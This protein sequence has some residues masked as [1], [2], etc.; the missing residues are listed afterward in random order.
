MSATA[1]FSSRCRTDDVPGIS[2]TF[3]AT[4]SVH[5]S[6]ICAGVRPSLLCRPPDHRVAED[7]IVRSEGGAER[8]ERNER[9]VVFDAGVEHRLRSP[10]D[11]VVGV[12]HADDLGA[13]QRDLQMLNDD[14]AQPDSADEPFVAGLD[15]RVELAVEQLAVDLGR[16]VRIGIFV[17]HAQIDR[18][19]PVDAQRVQVLLDAG[20]QFVGLLR[21]KPR[22]RLVAACTDLADQREVGGIGVQGLADQLV[23][24][25]RARRTVRCRCG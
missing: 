2:S 10:V 12:L 16:C 18:G 5:A 24:D 20:P 22:A 25:V 17:V 19:E 9:D 3:G 23:G 15:H 21:R 7:G 14:A 4:D 8:E 11:E 13:V 1:V 6:A